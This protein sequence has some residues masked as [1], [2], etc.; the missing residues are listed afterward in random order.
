MSFSCK[1]QILVVFKS[2]S[3]LKSIVGLKYENKRSFDLIKSKITS[4]CPQD[5][6]VNHFFVHFL[7]SYLQQAGAQD[8]AQ[9]GMGGGGGGGIYT[10]GGAQHGWGQI[11]IQW[12]T[13]MGG[14]GGGGGAGRPGHPGGPGGP[15]GPIGPMHPGIPG[16]PRHPGR[17]GGP[18]HPGCPGGPGCGH[19]TGIGTGTGHGG[20]GGGGGGAQHVGSQVGAHIAGHPYPQGLASRFSLSSE[21]QRDGLLLRMV[22]NDWYAIKL[23][24]YQYQMSQ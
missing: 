3:P 20:G 7:T 17:P 23:A 22:H 18:M 6:S 21:R 15:I 2:R 1:K 10:G 8:G 5:K 13:Q 9:T 24:W 4:F 16:N 12:W 19:G 14:Q 11:F